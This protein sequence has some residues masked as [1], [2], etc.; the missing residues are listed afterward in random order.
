MQLGGI[1]PNTSSASPNGRG[2]GITA[3]DIKIEHAAMS[4]RLTKLES[5]IRMYKMIILAAVVIYFL[6]KQK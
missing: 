1:N 2:L 5:D 3:D 6:T 4:E